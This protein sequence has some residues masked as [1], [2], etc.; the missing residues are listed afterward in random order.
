MKLKTPEKELIRL[1]LKE[2]LSRGDPTTDAFVKKNEKVRALIFSQDQ[3]VI[4]GLNIVRAIFKCLDSQIKFK[5][6]VPEGDRI[7][8]KTAIAEVKGKAG[9]LLKGER[10]ALNFIQ[11]LSGISTFTEQFVKKIKRGAVKITDTR[12]T[13]P[14]LRTLEKYAVKIGGGVSHRMTLGDFI[15]IKDNHWKFIPKSSLPEKV[16]KI[17]KKKPRMKIEIEVKKI[18]E[19]KEALEA[20]VDIIMLDNM[21]YGSLK[22]AIKL[23]K[24]WRKKSKSKKPAIEISGGVNLDNI[25][26]L[27]RLGADQISI[28]AL[29][30]S[31]PGFPVNMEIINE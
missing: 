25:S 1:A 8:A 16:K 14:G 7:K 4:S 23:I 12:K 26:K 5:F 27:S 18:S 17:R 21:S 31:A 30:H 9:A 3:G 15:L 13:T 28:G 6:L 20:K 10:T 22:K 24:D 11:H 2:D 19:L 29:T